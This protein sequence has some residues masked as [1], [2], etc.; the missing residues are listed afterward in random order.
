MSQAVNGRPAMPTRISLRR[1]AMPSSTASAST[2][3]SAAMTRALGRHSAAR[4]ASQAGVTIRL[5]SPSRLSTTAAGP[6]D[7]KPLST[8][9]GLGVSMKCAPS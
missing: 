5:I 1:T 6:R 2:T 9:T 3:S 8:K 4:S 7:L